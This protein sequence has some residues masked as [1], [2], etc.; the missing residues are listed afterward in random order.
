MAMTNDRVGR[1]VAVI[2]G[3]TLYD[4]FPRGSYVPLGY[5][6]RLFAPCADAVVDVTADRLPADHSRRC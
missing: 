1:H 4:A 6:C 5:K 3:A 2:G